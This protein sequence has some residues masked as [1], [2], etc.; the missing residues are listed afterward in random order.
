[1][2]VV[3]RVD[4]NKT[5]GIGHF[6]RCLSFAQFFRD[7]DIKVNFVTTTRSGYLLKMLEEENMTCQQKRPLK[8]PT[9]LNSC[10]KF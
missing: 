8:K 9:V 4:S 5:M 7:E 6:M 3:F 2:Q 1:M 10:T